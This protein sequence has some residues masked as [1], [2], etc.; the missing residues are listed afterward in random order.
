[1][2]GTGFE[3]EIVK[4]DSVKTCAV[5]PKGRGAKSGALSHDSGPAGPTSNPSD[6]PPDVADLACRL[7]ALPEAVR[8]SLLAAVKAAQP[9]ERKV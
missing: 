1:M 4:A 7:A 3:P 2:L 6:P 5:G 9:Q 8:A